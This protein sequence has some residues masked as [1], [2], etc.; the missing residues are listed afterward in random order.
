MTWWNVYFLTKF[1]LP[2]TQVLN[3][4]IKKA[5]DFLFTECPKCYTKYTVSD[6]MEQFT[7]RCRC[8]GMLYRV[9]AK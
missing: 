3:A 2:Q 4:S 5:G 6:A 7:R 1:T 8:C 9:G